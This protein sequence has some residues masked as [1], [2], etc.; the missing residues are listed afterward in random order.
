MALAPDRTKTLSK[1]NAFNI[2]CFQEKCGPVNL[3]IWAETTEIFVRQMRGR[4]Q[5]RGGHMG[6]ITL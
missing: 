6:G 2:N 4:S 5:K 1:N 3:E